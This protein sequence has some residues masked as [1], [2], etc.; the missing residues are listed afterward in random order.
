V[1]LSLEDAR[2]RID[3]ILAGYQRVAG[4]SGRSV[5]PPAVTA[6]K[7]YEA[8][9]LCRVLQ[10]L[11]H[12]EGYD[13]TLQESNMVR[14]K[15]APGPINRGYAHFQLTRADGEDLEV[16]TDVEFLA[17]SA[18]SRS[19]PSMLADRCDYHELDVVVVPTGAQGRPDVNAVRVGVECKNLAY[20]KDM[21]RALLGVRRELS[22]LSEETP[23]RFRSWPRTTVPANPPSCLLAYGT[24]PQIL[25]YAPPGE[26]FGID[27]IYE[28]LP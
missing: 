24:D 18:C 22:L 23:T 10:H 20:Q 4:A 3:R 17:L 1:A 11:H 8:W 19:V 5:L 25:E 7:T 16:W 2:R 15:S 28:P 14:L 6:G 27:F 12:D 26:L 9:V 21:L 13:I